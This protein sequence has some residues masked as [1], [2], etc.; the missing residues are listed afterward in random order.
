MK[1]TLIFFKRAYDKNRLSHLYLINGDLGTGKI[2]LAHEFAY[3]LLNKYDKNVNLKK[4]IIDNNHPMVYYIEP[5]GLSIKKEQIL[6]LQ[7]EFSKTTLLRGPRIYIIKDVDLISSGAANSLLKFM[8]EPESSQVFGLLLTTNLG[9]ILPT[10]I[11]RS[12][13]LNLESLNENIIQKRL[14]DEGLDLRMATNISYVTNS[15]DSGLEL[16]TDENFERIVSFLEDLI[17]KWPDPNISVS[18]LFMQNLSFLSYDRKLY[19]MLLELLLVYF[20]NIMRFKTNQQISLNYIKEDIQIISQS[21]TL[22]QLEKIT[23]DIQNEI[24]KQSYYI[25]ISLS[26]DALALQLEKSR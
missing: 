25:N 19:H 23:R 15:I 26:I 14:L 4:N 11:S 16:S 17:Q 22:N 6:E 21:L 20:Y 1:K 24:V 3:M 18:L 8:E 9:N 13:V 12:Q 5:D 2:E 7:R 10:I